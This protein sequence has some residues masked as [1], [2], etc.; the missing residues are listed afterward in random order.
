MR[1]V[2]TGA[3][4]A[5][6]LLGIMPPASASH[7]YPPGPRPSCEVSDRTVFPG[8]RVTVGGRGWKPN[9]LVTVGFKQ[10]DNGKAQR[11]RTDAAGDFQGTFQIPGW[12][13]DGEALMGCRGFERNRHVVEIFFPVRVEEEPERTAASSPAG[14]TT[15]MA[16][17]A[18]A[19]AGGALALAR[20]RRTRELVR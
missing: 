7:I 2:L 20:R 6:L 9:S 15:W 4:A 18:L 19:G 13:N 10:G 16:L 17:V 1:R 5:L 8:Q 3:V 11:Y 12:A 14:I